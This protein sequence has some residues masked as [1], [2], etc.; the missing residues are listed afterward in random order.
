MKN[1]LEMK[2]VSK[3]FRGFSLKDLSLSLPEG[4]ILGLAG[5]NGSGKSTAIR[6]ILNILEKDSGEIFLFGKD[7]REV[8]IREDVGVVTESMGFPPFLNG[9]QIN[10]MMKHIY[11]NWDADLFY[12]SLKKF[13]VPPDRRYRD[14]SRGM[15]LKL[16]LAAALYHSPKLL[17]L[18]EATAGLDP[19][20][21]DEILDILLD[22]T[23]EEVHSVLITSHIV[24]DLEKLCDYIAFLE[25]GRLLLS[26]EKDRLLE[27]YGVWHGTKEQFSALPAGAVLG[28]KETPYSVE[29]VV[30]REKLPRETPLSPVELEQLFIFMM[31]EGAE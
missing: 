19:S 1:A 15:A 23:R 7:H 22:F 14:L 18:D 10:K 24:G 6:L 2:H 31:K 5:K 11:Q 9:L 30:K 26:A 21:R 27:A 29:A 17:I 4:S 20:A 25:D 28:K 3:E 8:S 16:K 12:E 13:S